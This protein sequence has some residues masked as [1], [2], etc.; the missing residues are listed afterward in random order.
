VD[1]ATISEEAAQVASYFDGHAVDDATTP[2][3]AL[4]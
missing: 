3:A 1:E 2:S 4:G